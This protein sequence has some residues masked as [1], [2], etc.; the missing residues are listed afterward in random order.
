MFNNDAAEILFMIAEKSVD[1]KTYSLG[2]EV[3]IKIL[4]IINRVLEIT[5]SKTK[6]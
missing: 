6:N 3:G 2:S 5:A 4:D 1:G